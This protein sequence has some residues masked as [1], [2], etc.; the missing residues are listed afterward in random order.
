VVLDLERAAGA[1]FHWLAKT[2]GGIRVVDVW[3]S[4]EQYEAFADSQIGPHTAAAGAPAP[5]TVAVAPVHNYL[6]A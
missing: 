1:L 4:R 3:G 6:A 2:P 5:P